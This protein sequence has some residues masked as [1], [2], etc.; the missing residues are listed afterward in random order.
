MRINWNTVCVARSGKADQ[1]EA[2]FAVC[3]AGARAKLYCWHP[4]G[5]NCV[6]S[7]R[8]GPE[9]TAR[10]KL[11][12]EQPQLVRERGQLVLRLVLLPVHA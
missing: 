4:R 1:Q 12:D 6:Q 2:V 11:E 8:R 10:G 7:H 3:S 9:L 5:Q